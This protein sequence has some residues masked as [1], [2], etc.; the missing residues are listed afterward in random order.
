MQAFFDGCHSA[1]PERCASYASSP[2]EIAANLEAIYSSLR[3]QPVP[4]FTG[5]AFGALTYDALRGLVGS[6]ITT[7][8]AQFQ[9]LASGLA[10]LSKGNGTT[11]F[12]MM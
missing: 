6:A 10:D 2:S 11:L 12:Q 5:D 3:S 9:Q 7:P 4:A 1:G 8:Y